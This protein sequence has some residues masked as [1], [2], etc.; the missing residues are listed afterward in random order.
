MVNRIEVPTQIGLKTGDKGDE[1]G[2][3]QGYLKKFGYIRPDEVAP[4]GVKVDLEKAIEEPEPKDFDNKTEIALKEFQRF[5]SLPVTGILDKPTIN[6]MLKPRCGLPDFLVSEGQ[7][8]DYV[9][10][11]RKWDKL[12]LTYRFLNYTPDLA[13]SVVRRAVLDAFNQWA[14]ESCVSFSEVKS[15][16]DISLSWESGDHGDGS[17][18]DG[19]GGVLAHAFYPQDGRLHFDE[20]ELWTDDDPPT[21]FDLVT[22]ALHELGH[23]L[24]LSHSTDTQ[25]VMYAYYSGKRRTLRTDD[26]NGIQS[27]YG[28]CKS[29]CPITRTV[30]SSSLPVMLSNL[31]YLRQ[32]RD[33]IVLNSRFKAP[34]ESILNRYYQFTPAINRK[35]E[36]S[37]TFRKFVKGIVYPFIISAKW[38]TS[39]ANAT[40][41]NRNR[42]P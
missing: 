42:S 5:N 10:S 13:Q 32:F 18:F 2:R 14:S 17:A 4:F 16:G 8:D 1:V 33:E 38:V 11:G 41:G 12:A 22:V 36:K 24:G 29:I 28:S 7:V 19:P 37:S 27:I 20:D 30:S 9:Y 15:G 34:F 6:L 39:V 23:I 35:M 25:A 3:L 40:L 26:K 31:Q 21:G